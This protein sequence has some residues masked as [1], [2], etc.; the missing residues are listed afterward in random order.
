[1]KEI[2]EGD[3]FIGFKTWLLI[4]SALLGAR[5]GYQFGEYLNMVGEKTL[6]A[7]YVAAMGGMLIAVL[8]MESLLSGIS[9][10]NRKILR[11][12]EQLQP[13]RVLSAMVG[14]I[15]GVVVSYMIISPIAIFLD[16]ELLR[17]WGIYL[18]LGLILF[19]SYLFA[20][21]FSSVNIFSSTHLNNALLA[22]AGI[23]KIIDSNS[24]I[25]GRI[26]EVIKTGF[27]SGPFI[28]P[29]AVLKELQFLADS[30]DHARREKGRRGLDMVRKILS[31]GEIPLRILEEKFQEAEDVDST[32][33]QIARALQAQVITNDYNLNKLASI[34]GVKILNLNDLV[35]ALRPV[36]HH[37]DILSVEVVKYGKEPGQGVGYLEDGTMVVVEEGE[38]SIGKRVQG[39]ITSILQT[40][41]GRIIFI[42]PIRL[43][44]S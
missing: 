7:P 8:A 44:K 18:H 20:V 38:D 24:L 3:I 35:N 41:A 40:S 39:T 29:K 22:S 21:T 15:I 30:F 4:I 36:F 43:S 32:V 19:L 14:V 31:D 17:S 9:E 33:I 42:R 16:P 13:S 28:I 11:L 26:Y 10:V 27:L 23:P 1:M 6:Y 34:Y 12:V 5:I 25:D 37:G 2:K